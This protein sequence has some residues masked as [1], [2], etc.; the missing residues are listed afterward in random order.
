MVKLSHK[1]I[2]RKIAEQ[3]LT[4]DAVAELL[5]ISVRHVR[6]LC[7]NDTNAYISL[8][9]RLSKLF[10]TTIEELLLIPEVEKA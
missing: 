8:R 7:N 4:Q 3:N 5:D 9:Y 6:N 1:I 10:G 2:R